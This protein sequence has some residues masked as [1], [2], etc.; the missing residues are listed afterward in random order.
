MIGV[1]ATS[2]WVAEMTGDDWPERLCAWQNMP[3]EIRRYLTARL[4]AK[5]LELHDGPAGLIR[6]LY[7]GTER[8]GQRLSY[9]TGG[10]ECWAYVVHDTREWLAKRTAIATATERA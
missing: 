8:N 3:I 9:L 6:F 1:R 2:G 10:A 4:L 7:A 5:S